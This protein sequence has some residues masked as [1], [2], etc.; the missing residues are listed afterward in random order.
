[1][2]MIPEEESFSLTAYVESP[3]YVSIIPRGYL[4]S[5]RQ[6]E[7]W[8][9]PLIPQLFYGASGEQLRT[10]RQYISAVGEQ[11][12]LSRVGGKPEVPREELFWRRVPTKE[13]AVGVAEEVVE[14]A[15]TEVFAAPDLRPLLILGAIFAILVWGRG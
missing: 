12:I 14:R 3:G 9:A 2:F 7:T 15:V 13:E 5:R 10:W 8:I 4:V 1:M 11:V 6:S